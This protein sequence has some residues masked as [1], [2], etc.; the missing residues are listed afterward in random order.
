MI[1]QAIK[2]KITP[3]KAKYSLLLF[4][5][6]T[7]TIKMNAI[8]ARVINSTNIIPIVSLISSFSFISS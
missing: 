2:P 1:I 3:L 5:Y 8:N 7:A 4:I 6:I